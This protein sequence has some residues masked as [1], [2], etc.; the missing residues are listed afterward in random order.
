[1]TSASRAFLRDL[2]SDCSLSACSLTLNFSRQRFTNEEF[3]ELLELGKTKGLLAAEASMQKG[4]IVNPSEHRQALHTALRDPRPS[5]PH[6]EEV[7]ATL[8]R[9]RALA[10]AV[11][12]GQWRGCSGQTITDVVNIGI[13]GSEMGPKAVWHALQEAKPGIRL[14]FLSAADG[15]Q[16]DRVTAAIDPKRTLVVVSSKSFTTRETAANAAAMISWLEEQG[17]TRAELPHHLVLVTSNI[18]AAEKLGLPHDNVYPMWDWVGGRFSVWSAIG[19]PLAVALGPDV[20]AEF[21]AGAHEMDQHALTAPVEKNLPALLALFEYGNIRVNGIQSFVFLPYDERLRVIVSWL[22]QLEMESLGKAAPE[23]PNGK[24]TWTGLGVW[25]GHADEGQHS[26][27][28]WLREGT[29]CNS[30]DIVSC[31]DPGHRH[32]ELARV[33]AANAHAQAEALV[34]RPQ[35]SP[36]FN[37]VS[38]LELESL[39]PHSLG[40]LMAL[41]EHK[42]TMLG[43]LFGINAFDQPGVELGKKLSR[44]AEA[45][46][47]SD[48]KHE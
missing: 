37:S 9:I 44:Q 35:G 33:L 18:A 2:R 6:H 19:L 47:L 43:T 15:V 46:M 45:Q 11:R 48:E 39:T 25:G 40:A 13:G 30:I 16:F 1:M 38:C 26:Y 22:Q 29:C 27:F 5:A 20:F 32:Q 23:A 36:Y 8:A 12:S 41:Y 14:H 3:E 7:A 31:R 28:Q 21:L 17:I 4:D 42:T 24:S 10:Q 34:T